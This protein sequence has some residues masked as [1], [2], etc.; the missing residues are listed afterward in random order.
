[1]LCPLAPAQR[2]FVEGVRRRGQGVREVPGP[3][4]RAHNNGQGGQRAQ[5]SHHCSV[6]VAVRGSQR[7]LHKQHNQ[8]Q[9][10]QS[11]LCRRSG[12]RASGARGRATRH[13][14]SARYTEYSL[15]PFWSA[16]ASHRNRKG[17]FGLRSADGSSRARTCAICAP[18]GYGRGVRAR[19][20]SVS[21]SPQ[22]ESPRG[23][24]E[25]K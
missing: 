2:F 10:A 17:S 22:V 23:D 12:L 6:R 15:F 9:H 21:E 18:R 14:H 1:M 8:K 3:H 11:P 7:P 20:T 25:E 19:E 24:S 4:L 13:D 16:R 5:H